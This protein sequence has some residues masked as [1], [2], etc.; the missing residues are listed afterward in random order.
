MHPVD[1][2]LGLLDIIADAACPDAAG[3][4]NIVFRII[5]RHNQLEDLFRLLHAVTVV[6]LETFAASTL[7]Q[8]VVTLMN[9]HRRNLHDT[10]VRAAD[11]T[12]VT[13]ALVPDNVQV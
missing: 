3:L 7:F 5:L 2:R 13:L 6:Q 8:N 11:S 1:T 12:G 4:V 10:H 9:H